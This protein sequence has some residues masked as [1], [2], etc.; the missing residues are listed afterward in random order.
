MS[1]PRL[2]FLGGVSGVGKTHALQQL[3]RQ[4][5]EF[6]HLVAGR[7]IAEEQ[8]RQAGSDDV[9][10]RPRVADRSAAD[11]F[12]GFLLTALRR[13]RAVSSKPIVLDGHYVVPT[14]SGPSIVSVDIFHQMLPDA[15]LLLEAE[16]AAVV[17]R[18]LARMPRP[19]WWDESESAIARLL[20][21]ELEHAESVALQ[22][23][24]PL[25]RARSDSVCSV[26]SQALRMGSTIC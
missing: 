6:V 22:L 23:G 19:K 4:G 11:T 3:T 18:L 12:Q 26:V 9:Y 7:L 17:D 13:H 20:R 15:L 1:E 2:V 14:E 25:V 21:A 10:V 5:I 16:S 24:R 8:A